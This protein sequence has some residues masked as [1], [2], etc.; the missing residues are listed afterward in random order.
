MAF[1]PNVGSALKSAVVGLVGS[2]VGGA[3][4]IL[5]IA[6]IS[7]LALGFNYDQHPIPMVSNAS[8]HRNS[9]LSALTD[10]CHD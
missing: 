6:L 7:A 1:S 4:G 3:F 5:V 9:L 2:I 8:I 10:Q